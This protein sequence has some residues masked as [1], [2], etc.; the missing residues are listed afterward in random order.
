[1]ERYEL[2]SSRFLAADYLRRFLLP[3]DIAIDATMGNGHDTQMLCELVGETGHVY[4]FDVQEQAVTNTHA[5]LREMGLLERATLIHAGH[6]LMAEYVQGPVQAVTFNLGWL[7]GAGKQVRTLWGTT[8]IAV[9]SALDLLENGGICV[10]CVYPGHKE[11]DVERMELG[12]MLSGLRPQEFNVLHHRFI[13]AGPGAPECFLIQK[14][15]K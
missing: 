4:A 2:K 14:Q 12:E 5:R 3:G 15:G 13:N 10:I 9:H 1:M 6:Q 7:S 8:R 11:G